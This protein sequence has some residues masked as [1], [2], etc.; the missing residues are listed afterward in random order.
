VVSEWSEQKTFDIQ[1]M[2]TYTEDQKRILTTEEPDK[3][4]PQWFKSRALWWVNGKIDNAEF[5]S[6]MEYLFKH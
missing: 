3:G 2:I 5:I 4:L 1:E 6:G